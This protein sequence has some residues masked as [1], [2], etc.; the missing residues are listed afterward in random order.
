MKPRWIFLGIFRELL[1]PFIAGIL[2]FVGLLLMM[3]ALRLTEF[4]L[5]HGVSLTTLMELMGYLAL[6]FLPII[7]PMSL[8]VALLLTYTRL[9]SDNEILAFKSIGYSIWQILSPAFT[10]GFLACLFS[11]V[12]SFELAPW[13]EKKFEE[14]FADINRQTPSLSLREGTFTENFFDLVLFAEEV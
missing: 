10:L 9:S 2:V 12:T 1:T 13:G 8:M 14:L 7:L 4:V 5:I 3:Q 6:S 11:L